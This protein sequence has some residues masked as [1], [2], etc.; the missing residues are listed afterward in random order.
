MGKLTSEART[1]LNSSK[2]TKSGRKKR[3]KSSRK[4]AKR[5]LNNLICP[6]NMSLEQWQRELRSQEAENSVMGIEMIDSEA[7]PGEF[8][9]ISKSRRYKVVYHGLNSE[10]NFC[11]CMDFKTN[12][13]GTCKHIECVRQYLQKKKLQLKF[14]LPSYS[15]IYLSYNPERE[16]KLRI[17]ETNAEAIATLAAPYFKKRGCGLRSGAEKS[18][19]KFICR[20]KELDPDFRIYPD[21]M[22]YITEIRDRA[23]REAILTRYDDNAIDSLLRTP[24]YQYQRDGVRFA[25]SHGRSII[26]DEMG[27]GKTIQAI[28]T[29]ELLRKEKFVESVLIMCPTS[30]KYQWKKE[31]ER[32]AGAS[33]MVVEGDHLARTQAYRD[34]STVYKIVSYHSI[35]ND[36][37]VYKSMNCDLIIMD[38][39]Q[40]LK[41]WNTQ[42]AKAARLISSNYAVVLSGTPLENKL[43]ELY[44]VMQLVN[45]FCLGPF[46]I[47]RDKSIVTNA[48]TGKVVGYKNLN[49][50]GQQVSSVLLR[51][52]KKQ[53]KLQ[54][55]ERSDKILYVDMTPQQ[56]EIHDECQSIVARIIRKWN[57]FHFLSDTERKRL[58][59]CLNKMRMVCDSTFI[60]DQSTFYHTKISEAVNIIA[61]TIESSDEKIVVFSQWER[62]ARLLAMELEKGSI[63]YEFLHGGVPSFK[64]RQLMDNFTEDPESRVFISTDAGS[65][66]LNLQ[67]ASTLINLDLPWNPAVLE[68]RIA[69]IYRIGQKNNIQVIN[70]VAINTIEERMLSTLN[71]K[72]EMFAGILDAGEDMVFIENSKFEKIINTFSEI[73]E[74]ETETNQHEEEVPTPEQTDSAPIPESPHVSDNSQST[75]KSQIA[76]VAQHRASETSPRKS[77]NKPTDTTPNDVINHGISFLNG[78]STIL[79]DKHKTEELL[80]AIVKTDSATGETA[81]HIPVADKATV[82]NIFTALGKLFSAN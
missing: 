36:L 14:P 25:F 17:G 75:D 74:P 4:S 11:S 35:A 21:A 82:A 69:R 65:T 76:N 45:Q 63:K 9:V 10:W 52:T 58:L 8:A 44:S 22:D 47:F 3:K 61:D 57:K 42:I 29:A 49:S 28:A 66:G 12:G 7:S 60:I 54:M 41:N 16:V 5:Q 39:V 38:E 71:F 78:L 20:A 24:L 70:M 79:S 26:A 77:D 6:A 33:V 18:L 56:R 27:L 68:Q 62:M 23:T 64:R 55:P 13:L 19:E 72:S 31:I 30:L 53:V 59:L 32:F 80:N 73:V 67:V 37:K 43:E 2:D 46:Y 81:I 15:S 50:I 51:R 34:T 48:N 40:R 1:Q